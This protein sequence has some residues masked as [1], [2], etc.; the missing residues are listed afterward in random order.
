VTR[1]HLAELVARALA[2]IHADSPSY[3]ALLRELAE[4]CELPTLLA[5]PAAAE[6]MLELRKL[7]PTGLWV[8]GEATRALRCKSELAL[9]GAICE[10]AAE[11]QPALAPAGRECWLTLPSSWDAPLLRALPTGFGLIT[12]V[13]AELELLLLRRGAP[14]RAL[15][16]RCRS[17]S[18][19]PAM[20]LDL[21]LLEAA[22]PTGEPGPEVRGARLLCAG[23]SPEQL[24][25][26]ELNLGISGLVCD[27]EQALAWALRL[28]AHRIG[29]AL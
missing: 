6:L 27:A 17:L 20:R 23:L 3:K 9:D 21:V 11:S 7:R 14:L 10:L 24:G 19:L 15:G 13:V 26:A 5:Q 16:V 1:A 2:A 28:A 8:R 22:V 12:P 29:A 18:E 4:A 25:R